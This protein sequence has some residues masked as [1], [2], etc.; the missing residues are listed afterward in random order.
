MIT[1]LTKSSDHYD[2]VI[3]CLQERYD[4]PR[5]INQTH[6]CRI[7]EAAPLKD[8]T[9]NEI[10]ALYDVVIQHLRALKSISHKP[11]GSFITN[12]PFGDEVG[13]N[14]HIRIVKSTLMSPIVNFFSIF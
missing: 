5:Q 3:K 11:S 13:P 12:V 14:H 10:R 2:E 4:C 7:V 8:G 6:V 1:G 9:C